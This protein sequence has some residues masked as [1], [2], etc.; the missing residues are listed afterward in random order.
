M[1]QISLFAGASSAGA[2]VLTMTSREIAE[3]TGKR[4]DN[5]MVDCRKLVEFYAET[6]SPEKSGEFVKSSTYKDSTGRE[7]PCY[8]LNKMAS[9]DLVTGYSLPHRHAVNKRWQELEA[10]AAAG[11]VGAKPAAVVDV[12]PLSVVESLAACVERNVI[13]KADSALCVKAWLASANPAFIGALGHLSGAPSTPDVVAPTT[14]ASAQLD[15]DVAPEN[16]D[17]P[18]FL[19]IEY[20]QTRRGRRVKSRPKF[21]GTPTPLRLNTKGH[22]MLNGG[23]EFGMNALGLGVYVVGGYVEVRRALYEFD[24]DTITGEVTVNGARFSAGGRLR[25]MQCWKAVKLLRHLSGME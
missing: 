19:R 8:E 13:S 16:A 5:V 15:A 25:G 6:Y 11:Q 1:N 22:A 20:E 10:Q 17:L 4:H 3:L 23:G 14:P 9:L 7:L 21:A 24:I 18:H 2:E 12:L